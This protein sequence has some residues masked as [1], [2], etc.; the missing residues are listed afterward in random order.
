MQ[1]PIPL[2]T[3]HSFLVSETLTVKSLL[4]ID[5]ISQTNPHNTPAT[6]FSPQIA[7]GTSWLKEQGEDDSKAVKSKGFEFEG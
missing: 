4:V 1:L 3:V 5:A 2:P 7:S 6:S